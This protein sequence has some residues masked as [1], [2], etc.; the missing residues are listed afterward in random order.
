MAAVTY[1]LL[2]VVD[3]SGAVVSGATVAI[4][5]VKDKSGTDISSPGA[6][7]GQSGA[8]VSVDYDAEAKGE[9]WVVLAISKVGSA[10]T[11]LNAAPAF[12]LARD[13]SRIATALPNVAPA[14]SGGLPTVDSA[15]G[16]KFSVGTGA[17]QISA[18]AGVVNANVVTWLGSSPNALQSG[19]I[20]AYLGSYAAN[21]AYDALARG[22][23]SNTIQLA[24]SASTV[25]GTYVGGTC[26]TV[27]TAGVSLS[28]P[29]RIVNY[30]GS[31]QTATVAGTFS[32]V[33]SSSIGYV[34][35]A[36]VAANVARWLDVAPSALSSQ[37]VQASVTAPV[38]VGTNNDKTGYTASTVTDKTGYA[39][40]ATG[41]DAVII[42]AG[43][44]LKA[45]TKVILAFAGDKILNNGATPV[46][47]GGAGLPTPTTGSHT[48]ITATMGGSGLVDRSAT[49]IVLSTT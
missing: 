15:N 2:T 9:A 7:V 8:N 49:A 24:T 12:Y 3:D 29:F 1:P 10:F 48:V 5:S 21:L 23:S 14:A 19:R 41:L 32:P 6:T 16:V 20:D 27:S 33:P 4:A 17:G 36:E 42:E 44:T 34:I 13:S 47:V 37:L 26:R 43:Y 40:S 46:T 11:G 31:T 18:V 45:A 25:D 38:T 28:G 35:D 22:G 39:L 30:V